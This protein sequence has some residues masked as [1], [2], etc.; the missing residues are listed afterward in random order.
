MPDVKD[1]FQIDCRFLT[2]MDFK[3]LHRTFLDAFSDYFVPFQISESQLENHIAQ[4]SVALERSV[5]AFCGAEMIGFTLNGFGDWNG[6]QTVYDAGTGV[7]PAYRKRGVGRALFDFM[8]PRFRSDGYQQILL[9]VISK[10]TAA[11]RL[12]ESLGFER[13]RRLIFFEGREKL[14]AAAV[15][16]FEVREIDAPDWPFF[17]SFATGRTSWQ[18]SV[19]A[20][21]RTAR[22]LVLGIFRGARC[23]GYG[24][25]FPSSGIISQIAVVP[26]YRRR[27][28]A[29][30][31]VSEMQR[32]LAP[33][34]RLRASNVDENL[35]ELVGFLENLGFT[36]TLS[37]IEMIKPLY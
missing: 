29:R 22:K 18:N 10:N 12:Y 21:R 7:R 30:A 26:E 33:E 35:A 32:R 14:P 2:K 19:T 36:E 3:A 31:L 9:E 4:N 24:A 6:R 11:L 37:Q 8:T 28:A 27:G 13:T 34:T 20:L 5:G 15:D 25:L 16:G 23:V 17:E 1:N